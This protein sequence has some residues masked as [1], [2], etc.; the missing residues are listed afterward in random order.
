[1]GNAMCFSK[2]APLATLGLLYLHLLFHAFFKGRSKFA[3]EV[4]PFALL[5]CVAWILM[6][7]YDYA[8]WRSRADVGLH[9]SRPVADGQCYGLVSIA[10]QLTVVPTMGTYNLMIWYKRGTGFDAFQDWDVKAHFTGVVLT[11]AA[12]VLYYGAWGSIWCILAGFLLV[13]M[14][15]HLLLAEASPSDDDAIF[16]PFAWSGAR[17]SSKAELEGEVAMKVAP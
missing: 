15:V 6:E 4:K 2:H 11:A 5:Y 17:G 13:V 10:G 8:Q 1:M 7:T 16:H 12:L 9:G 3:K 14:D